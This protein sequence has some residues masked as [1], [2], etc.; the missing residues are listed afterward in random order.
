M[1]S[2]PTIMIPGS[3]KGVRVE[4]R[5]LE[6]RIQKAV[7]DGHRR[8][9]V[10]AFGQHGIGGRLWRAGEEPVRIRVTG[11]SGQR[12]IERALCTEGTRQQKRCLIGLSRHDRGR[13]RRHR[14]VAA[15][16]L[17]GKRGQR[18]RCAAHL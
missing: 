8:I 18:A 10:Q 16:K 12:L 9:E 1:S 13:R 6:E 14:G 11:H 15:S 2:K 17:A 3:E 7:A 5:V 4:S